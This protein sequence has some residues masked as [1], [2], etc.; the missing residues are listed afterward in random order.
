[1]LKAETQFAFIMTNKKS[2]D[3]ARVTVHDGHG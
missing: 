1:V 2:P 3:P